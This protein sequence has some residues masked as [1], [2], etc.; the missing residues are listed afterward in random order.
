M[1]HVIIILGGWLRVE[2]LFDIMYTTYLG[3]KVSIVFS[4]LP[5]FYSIHFSDCQDTPFFN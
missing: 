3:K 1:I 5:L 4:Y 2:Y